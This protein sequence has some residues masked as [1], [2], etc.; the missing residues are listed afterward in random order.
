MT[1]FQL[2][3][4]WI[5]SYQNK[6]S[7]KYS[8]DKQYI[9]LALFKNLL[10]NFN[11]YTIL[12]A[13]DQFF[14]KITKDKASILLFA[15]KKYFPGQFKDLIKEKDIIQYQRMLPWYSKENQIKIRS[16]IQQ[17]RNYLYAISLTQEDLDSMFDTL[18]ELKNI[19]MEE[20][21]KRY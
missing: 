14:S 13:T 21:D 19:P 10:K 12:E 9:E 7:E 4:Y 5:S 15:S 18:E 1:S 3:K 20:I 16:Y 11:Y 2:R 6:F 8:Q 17:Y